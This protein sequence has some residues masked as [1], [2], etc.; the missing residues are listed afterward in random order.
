MLYAVICTD[1]PGSLPLRKE[2]RPEHLEHLNSL[3]DQLVFAGPFT[4]ADG[5]TMNGSLVVIEAETLEDA[6]ALA[7]KD[8]FF[9]HG[10]FETIDI[11]PWK[12]SI[13]NPKG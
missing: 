5:V 12:W 9:I 7:E 6:R 2:K 1:K 8:P 11:R 10:V 4:E 3:G 13:K